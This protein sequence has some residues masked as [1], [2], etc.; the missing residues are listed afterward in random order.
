MNYKKSKQYHSYTVII[1]KKMKK[2]ILVDSRMEKIRNNV[3]AHFNH[4][5]SKYYDYF[6]KIN[7]NNDLKLLIEIKDYLYQ[8]EKFIAKVRFTTK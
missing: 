7:V 6:E 8:V 2:I 1:M 5:F 4:N 3:S